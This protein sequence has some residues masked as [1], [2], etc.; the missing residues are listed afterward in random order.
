MNG[1]DDDS[2]LVDR[3]RAGDP[4]A[5][6]EA[7]TRHRA[8]L[9]R[10]VEAR[11][12]RRVRGR[13]DPSDVLTANEWPDAYLGLSPDGTSVTAWVER[14]A[15]RF[16]QMT[17]TVTGTEPPVRVNAPAVG[18]RGAVAAPLRPPHADRVGG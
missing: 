10:M 11:L 7:L 6:G 2:R 12:D 4:A 1:S 13:V 5:A 14:G 8:R 17:F 18:A 9:R 15:N 16:E 3:A